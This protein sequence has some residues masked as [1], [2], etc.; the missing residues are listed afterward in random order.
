MQR[1]Y[2]G[3]CISR[4]RTRFNNY[5]SCHR[6]CCRGHCVIQ[7]SFHAHFML[8]GHCCTHESEIIIIDKWRNKQETRKKS[9]FGNVSVTHLY[10]MVL[11]SE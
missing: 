6:K 10:R 4:F 8:D 3:S 1:Q 9:F 5:H 2:E 7:G 11:L